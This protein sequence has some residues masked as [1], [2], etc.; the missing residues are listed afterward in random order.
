MGYFP[1]VGWGC[2]S[3]VESEIFPDLGQGYVGLGDSGVF[4]DA[5]LCVHGAR[6]HRVISQHF[7]GRYIGHGDSGFIT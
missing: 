6:R 4:P 3:L 7:A 5:W 1:N 2:L